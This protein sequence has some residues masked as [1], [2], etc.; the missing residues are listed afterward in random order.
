MS[1]T[2]GPVAINTFREA[3][4]DRVLYNL[5][6]FALVMIGA[7][8]LVGQI[9]IGIERL[10]IVNLGLSAISLFGLVMAI[11]IGVGL[12]SKEIEKRTLYSLLAKPIRRWEFLVGKYAGLLLT[13]TV[14]TAFMTLG[15]AGALF[16][17]GRPLVQQDV[18]D[19][20]IAIAIYFILLGLALV[21][22]LA[23]FFCASRPDAFHV[24]YAGDLHHGNICKGHS[25]FRRFHT[26]S[27]GESIDA[28]G[29]LSS[30]E[31]SQLQ[32]HRGGRVWRADPIFPG[33]PEHSICSVL[34]DFAFAGVVRYFFEPRPK[35]SSP[36]RR[37]VWITAACVPLL[38]VC[39][40]ALQA[41]IDARTRSAVQERDELLLSSP[42]AVQKISLGYDSL[43]ADIYWTRTVQ[44]YGSRVATDHPNFDLLWPLLDITTTL[45]PKLVIAY[46]FGAVFLSEKGR[47]GAGRTDLAIE[48]VKRG[49]A[50]NPDQWILG[51]DLGFLY[52]W[53]MRDYSDSATAY[54]EA[55]KKPNA[56]LW[57]KIMAAQVAQ[58]GGSVE[59]SRMIWSELY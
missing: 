28:G 49:I 31:F 34:R 53:R 10:V 59:T 54:L 55:S 29:L 3:V 16:Y 11:F 6:F 43:M 12:V 41:G 17:V 4:R 24:I 22:A 20:S 9:S 52:Y 45:D 50:A 14:N 5:I 42:S 2:T 56:P 18:S 27:L 33:C 57:L 35:M 7:A 37:L 36:N 46:R 58:K 30:P 44:Y 13:L 1:A 38:F 23:I 48:L 25:R 39:V 47:G 8:I 21:T 19:V 26:Q 15:L 32:R 40:A 51:S